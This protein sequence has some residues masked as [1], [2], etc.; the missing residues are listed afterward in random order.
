[1][2]MSRIA[3]EIQSNHRLILFDNAFSEFTPDEYMMVI[4]CKFVMMI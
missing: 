1:M 4:C 2:M 3:L